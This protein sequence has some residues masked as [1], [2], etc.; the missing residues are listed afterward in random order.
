MGK[1]CI[2][3]ATGGLGS[4]VLY[5][6]LHTLN[7]D[8]STLIVSLHTPSKMLQEYAK[9][10]LD[11][12]R[13]DFT[14]PTSLR[15]AFAGASALLIISY[16]SIA[17]DIRVA[18]HQN[19]IDVAKEMGVQHVYYTSLAFASDSKAA[20]M[21]AHLSTEAYL[22][23]S[24]LTYTIIR[25][26]IYSESYAL[27][28]GFFDAETLARLPS[29]GRKVVV[30]GQGAVAWVNRDDLGQG[31]ACI[32]LAPPPEYAART[33]LLSGSTAVGLGDVTKV[34]S[35]IFHWNPPLRLEV[36]DAAEYVDLHLEAKM[37]GKE[38]QATRDY[39]QAWVTSYSA[40]ERGELAVVDPLLEKLLGRK[41]LPIEETLREKLGVALYSEP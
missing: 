20:V 9:Y 30:A 10:N 24:G 22:K 4:R 31:T 8:P 27:Y 16:P 13:G 41:T 33:V 21:Q 37:G 26:G 18:A 19:A 2:T 36:F 5:H 35:E 14:D 23:Q 29:V 17:Y 7:V 38:D 1:L 25:E 28:L 11:V 12:R 32:L 34:I 40:I 3:G 6:L 15:T 39:L